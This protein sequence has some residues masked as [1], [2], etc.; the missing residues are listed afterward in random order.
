MGGQKI[1]ADVMDL[2][3]GSKSSSSGLAGQVKRFIRIVQECCSPIISPCHCL[4]SVG[5]SA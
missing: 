4:I 2:M 5:A 1:P 3:K